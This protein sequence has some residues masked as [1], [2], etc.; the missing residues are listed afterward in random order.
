[1]SSR[2]KRIT[3]S[4]TFY[5]LTRRGFNYAVENFSPLN[6][7]KIEQDNVILYSL[8]E[9]KKEK[10]KYLND[11]STIAIMAAKSGAEIELSTLTVKKIYEEQDKFDDEVE[12]KSKKVHLK[13]FLKDNISEKA[14]Q[15]FRLF[16]NICESD[17]Q[18]VFHTGADVK[19]YWA[20]VTL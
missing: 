2:T 16:K 17:C 18:I 14:F 19:K 4:K 11:D 6:S 8:V 13:Q 20:Q 10:K 7:K 15:S 9:T 5:Y 12:A 1:L 3:H